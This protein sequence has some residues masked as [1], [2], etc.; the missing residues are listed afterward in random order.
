[1]PSFFGRK[2]FS[3][4]PMSWLYQAAVK[5]V[6]NLPLIL[7]DAFPTFLFVVEID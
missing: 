3:H 5:S 4:F 2:G 6:F 1:M 7:I